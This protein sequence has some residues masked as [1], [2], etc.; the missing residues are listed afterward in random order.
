MIDLTAMTNLTTGFDSERWDHW[1]LIVCFGV[2][3]ACGLWLSSQWKR[4]RLE[5]LAKASTSKRLMQIVH[6]LPF[7]DK[8]YETEWFK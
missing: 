7:A 8:L 6:R 1:L 4:E 2:V 5:R 3:S